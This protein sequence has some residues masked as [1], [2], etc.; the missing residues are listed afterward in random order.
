ME[1]INGT[2]KDILLENLFSLKELF[3]DVFNEN[4]VGL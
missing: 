1:K 4:N 3:P 2:N